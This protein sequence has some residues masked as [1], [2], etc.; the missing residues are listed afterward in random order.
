VWPEGIH[1]T[2]SAAGAHLTLVRGTGGGA[3]TKQQSAPATSPLRDIGDKRVEARR[4]TGPDTGAGGR[5]P[6]GRQN[7]VCRRR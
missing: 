6:S 2:R 5:R 4:T 7:P 3:A 1:G